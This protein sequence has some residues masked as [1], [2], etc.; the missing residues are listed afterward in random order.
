MQE[1]QSLSACKQNASCRKS[2]LMGSL[3]LNQ[4]GSQ[5]VCF[6]QEHFL[7]PYIFW[8]P[9]FLWILLKTPAIIIYKNQVLITAAYSASEIQKVSPSLLWSLLLCADT[10]Q[11]VCCP[12]NVHKYALFSEP[13]TILPHHNL[14]VRRR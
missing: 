3:I 12:S 14:D 8:L 7:L 11:S 2:L 9:V 1:P 5:N 10:A 4:T 6:R 13:Q